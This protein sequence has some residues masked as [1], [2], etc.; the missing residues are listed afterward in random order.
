MGVTSSPGPDLPRP[1]RRSIRLTFAAM[2][3]A[4]VVCLVAL[5]VVAVAFTSA[6][7]VIR[8][9]LFSRG[10]PG[11]TDVVV[12]T[13][14][15]VIVVLLA[16]IAMRSFARR[17]ARDVSSLEAR[18]SHLADE[19]LP[20]VLRGAREP[21]QAADGG[22]APDRPRAK[23]AEIARAVAA[24]DRLQQAAITAAEHEATMRNGIAQ[25]FVSLARRNQ[26]LLQKQL[27]LIDAL[28]QKAADPGALADLFLLDHLT[29]RMRR[30]AEN[31]IILSGE[32][33]GRSW[34]E[35]VPVI[36]VLRG[37][38]AE[39]E[40][41]Q[42]IRVLTMAQDAVAGSAAADMIHLLA[43]LIENAAL[44]S[45]SGTKVEVRAERVANG[46]AIEVEDRGL[47]IQPHLLAEI[48]QRLLDPAD[49]ALADPDRLGLFVVSKLASR[50]GVKVTLKPSPYGG[51]T[52]VA[53][54]PHSVVVPAATPEIA[55]A[56]PA[57]PGTAALAGPGRPSDG[58]A[59]SGR[60]RGPPEATPDAPGQPAVGLAS[61][62][63]PL[64][65]VSALG[66]PGAGNHAGRPGA[67]NHAG[68]PGA[69]NHA[70]R[71]ASADAP[72]PDSTAATL[73]ASGPDAT[74]GASS[75][76][77]PDATGFA[78]SP[79]SPDA[80]GFTPSPVSPDATIGAPSPVSPDA[81]GFTPSPVS[82]DAAGF[83]PSPVS[84]DATV[85][86]PGPVMADAATT[87]ASAEG[88]SAG[89]ARPAGPDT[90]GARPSPFGPGTTTGAPS[91]FDPDAAAPPA[92]RFGPGTPDDSRSP[93]R[94]PGSG[95][96]SPFSL[97]TPGSTPSPTRP[98]PPDA[99][100][101]PDPPD[102]TSRP[103]PPDATSRPGSTTSATSPPGPAGAETAAG[104]PGPFS[105][106]TRGGSRNP[107]SLGGSGNTR[108]PRSPGAPGGPAAAGTPPAATYRGLPRRVRQAS[109]S[110]HL[111]NGPAPAEGAARGVAA[112]GPSGDR[113]PEKARDFVAS[114]RAGWQ[115]E[116]GTADP[117][118]PAGADGD[119]DSRTAPGQDA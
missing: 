115:R 12:Y 19:Q 80:T 99:T 109:L 50:H 67:G 17:M 119:Q 43:E 58:L 94:G 10:H 5:W 86:A 18:A 78:P 81:T 103:D 69:G 34:S 107:F 29:T 42:R 110:E 26:S 7:A 71:P 82:P 84:P 104:S 37:A 111:R 24:M 63:P 93:S 40:D 114:F 6:G 59:L 101:R 90:T 49:F 91:V 47:G 46:F 20:Q 9:G 77:T 112:S 100:S 39:V 117:H 95:S 45:P 55:G 88:M 2:V 92:S 66:R 65:P 11:L 22:Q 56:Q 62:K 116:N 74:V 98:D 27:R 15:S 72:G 25:V 70:D 60:H 54:M 13:G 89:S 85:Y 3:A 35:P 79:V 32:P 8:H 106:E 16:A 28:E 57:D 23:T 64:R 73:S 87:P 41:Y 48:N 52:A 113:P 30:H 38:L 61:A 53:L 14:G 96:R 36:D 76:V 68:P 21:G 102:A 4:P 108:D 44:F 1:A 33:P 51:I 31:L 105:P 97:S 118:P 83:A 75:P